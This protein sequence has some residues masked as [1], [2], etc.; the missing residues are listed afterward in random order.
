MKGNVIAD[1]KI[2]TM[3]KGF[4]FA[5]LYTDRGTPEDEEN[6]TL[7]V[8]RFGNSLP[9]YFVLDGEG[10]V[11]SRLEGLSTVAGFSKFLQQGLDAHRQRHVD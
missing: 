2:Q 3:L 5:E 1:W 9:L 4:I 8:E 6:N 11:L 7:R 10:N